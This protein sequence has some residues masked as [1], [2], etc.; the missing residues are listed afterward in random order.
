MESARMSIRWKVVLAPRQRQRE[1]ATGEQLGPWGHETVIRKAGS[2]AC[3]SFSHQC[4]T[5]EHD[6]VA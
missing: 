3:W 2:V 1:K 6:Q 5:S 4:L